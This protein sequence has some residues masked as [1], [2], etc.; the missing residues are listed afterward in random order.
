MFYNEP[1]S[2][3]SQDAETLKVSF[4]MLSYDFSLF[5]RRS[6]LRIQSV[7]QTEWKKR[8]FLPIPRES[9]PPS[10]PQKVHAI[11]EPAPVEPS[12]AAALPAPVRTGTPV[13]QSIQ[14]GNGSTSQSYPNKHT[15]FRPRSS[16]PPLSPNVNVDMSPDHE[17][18]GDD[19]LGMEREAGSEE[20]V[21]QLEKG[22]PK[23]EGFGEAG[24]MDDVD[25]VSF[26]KFYLAKV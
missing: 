17:G 1:D 25:H 20:I 9:P 15:V 11:N 19:M 21:K 18:Q 16:P 12:P 14:P 10:A 3:I 6:V 26:G 2:Q 7:L 24:W 8:S 23:W 13:T 4:V 22:M 5:L